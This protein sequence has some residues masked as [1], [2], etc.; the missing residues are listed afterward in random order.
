M[1]TS[2]SIT[3]KHLGE[4][5]TEINAIVRAGADV[6]LIQCDSEITS[7]APY[8][9][10]ERPVLKGGGG[11]DFDPV[12]R[13]LRENRRECY[14]GCIFLTDGFIPKPTINPHCPVLWIITPQMEVKHGWQYLPKEGR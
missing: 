13:W 14:G 6:T 1:D 5:L 2:G 10:S 11:N 4:F 8:R 3:E 12:M 9:R 7:V